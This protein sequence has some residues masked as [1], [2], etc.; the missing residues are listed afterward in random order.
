[1]GESVDVKFLVNVTN[2][3][4]EMRREMLGEV[5]TQVIEVQQAL[6]NAAVQQKLVELGWTPPGAYKEEVLRLSDICQRAH[7]RL[8]RGDEDAE[9]LAMLEEAWNK[10]PNA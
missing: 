2:S 9:I 5:V 1:M 6:T 8:L 7:D 4:V 3:G 10:P